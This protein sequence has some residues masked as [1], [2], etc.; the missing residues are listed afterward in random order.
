MPFTVASLADTIKLASEDA[1]S[2]RN[3]ELRGTGELILV[4]KRCR[5]MVHSY[6]KGI[7]KHE[8]GRLPRDPARGNWGGAW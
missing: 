8:K 3:V 4:Q 2:A 5:F 7:E 6:V 1:A